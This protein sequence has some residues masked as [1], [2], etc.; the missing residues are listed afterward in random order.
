MAP[1]PYEGEPIADDVWLANY[2]GQKRKQD[3]KKWKVVWSNLILCIYETWSLRQA[4]RKYRKTDRTK[5]HKS[6]SENRY[7]CAVSYRE[8]TYLVYGYL[9]HRRYPLP[10][11]AYHAIRKTFL[12]HKDSKCAGY[13]DGQ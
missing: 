3:A 7:L 4:G 6:D 8:F 5:Y 12:E 2:K 10:A 1:L 9:G 11:C 13:D